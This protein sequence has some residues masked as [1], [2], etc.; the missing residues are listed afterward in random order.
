M[1]K[2]KKKLLFDTESLGVQLSWLERYP[3]KVDVTGSNPVTPTMH[4]IP[5]NLELTEKQ[6]GYLLS[7]VIE[8]HHAFCRASKFD[9]LRE[10]SQEKIMAVKEIWSELERQTG[11]T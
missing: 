10:E 5:I 3:Y 1:S 11:I 8:M 9:Y 6:A 4:K 2:Y 7:A